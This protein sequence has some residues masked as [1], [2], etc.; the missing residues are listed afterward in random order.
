MHN[1][2]FKDDHALMRWDLLACWG[3]LGLRCFVCS[4][5]IGEFE[6]F[7]SIDREGQRKWVRVRVRA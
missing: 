2:G 5:L 4:A 3:L 1:C 6:L 7:R